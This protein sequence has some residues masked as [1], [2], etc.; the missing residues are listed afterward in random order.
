[1]TE[2]YSF[3]FS[4]TSNY[5]HAVRLVERLGIRPGLV[6]DLGAGHGAVAEPL[7]ERGFTYVA[8]DI[9]DGA[10]KDVA[11]RGFETH[12]VDVTAFDELGDSLAAVADG[13]PVSAVLLL[14]VLE[15]VYPTPEFLAGLHAA[16]ERLDRPIL[17]VSV[18]NIAHHDISAKLAFGRFDY[19]PTG[20]LDDT[21]VSFFTEARLER[22]M[23]G[24]GFV[25]VDRNDFELARSDQGFP[26]ELPSLATTAPPAQL[27]RWWRSLADPY[28]QVNQF[29]RAYL[30]GAV[31]V[32]EEPTPAEAAPE[33]FLS[34]LMRTQGRRMQ[35]LHE[36][37]LC[38]AAQTDDD[39]E[40]QLLV[41]ADDVADVAPIEEVVSQFD[42]TFAHRVAVVPVSG[43]S[44]GRPL[45]VGL[46]RART[47]Y[48]AFL[49]DD[50]LVSADWV[51]S[52]HAKAD[53]VRV[54]RSYTAEREVTAPAAGQTTPY[55]VTSGLGL[56]WVVPFD[57][58]LHFRQNHTPICS[59]AVPR[60]I[61]H[62]LGLRFDENLV[63]IEDW[64]FLMR[65]AMLVGVVDTG[66]VTSIYN[67]WITG[68]SS[69]SLHRAE[70]WQAMHTVL[71]DQ[72]AQVPVVLP[73]GSVTQ[74]VELWTRV[75]VAERER[76]SA[77]DR[78]DALERSRWWRL[79][80]TP[81]KVAT[82]LRAKLRSLR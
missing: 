47:R 48:V 4:W 52:F 15:H 38:L 64:H 71:L 5:G 82:R 28:G 68:E 73:A 13:R 29:I 35:P 45:N 21:H 24:A 41:H 43:G 50:D 27:L 40:V 11:E 9:D 51:E 59:F 79:T 25:H 23:R 22:S 36:A 53:D 55:H 65:A 19:T 56:R 60:S 16:L 49:D 81:A 8:T 30:P 77:R 6:L 7:A 20:L 12:H 37:L 69:T 39:F 54:V 1:M 66:T 61:Y 80:R 76:D 46:G 75:E 78:V 58:G 42:P 62:D 63:V 34:V 44:R 32:A 26:M 31:V 72:F 17:L 3:A 2:R 14:D 57:L 74:L 67:R 18:P 70:L 10:L 33:R